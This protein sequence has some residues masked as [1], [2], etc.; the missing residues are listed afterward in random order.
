MKQLQSLVWKEWH[1]VRWFLG[2]ALGLFVGMPILGALEGLLISEYRQRHFYFDA[3]PW[4]V[5]FGLGGVLAVMVAVGLV[6]LDLGG[7]REDFLRSRPLHLARWVLVKYLVGLIVVV[8]TCTLPLV[9]E[10]SINLFAFNH[11]EVA[12][13]WYPWLWIALYSLSFLCACLVRR[14]AHATMLAMAAMLLLYFLPVVLPFLKYISINWV[15]DRSLRL[16]THYPA[17]HT[18]LP[19]G[20]RV[21]PEQLWFVAGM[22]LI[23]AVALLASVIT[24]ARDWRVESGTKSMYWSAGS[25]LLILFASASFRLASNLP[26]LQQITLPQDQY[27]GQ[28]LFSG[29]RGIVITEEPYFRPEHRRYARTISLGEKGL[30]LG[31]AVELFTWNQ[32]N[33]MP[34]H[35]GMLFH[36]RYHGETRAVGHVDLHILS[37]DGSVPEQSVHLWDVDPKQWSGARACGI[38]DRIYALGSEFVTIDV[39]NPANAKIKLREPAR[40]SKADFKWS[41]GERWVVLSRLSALS[42]RQRLEMQVN[43]YGQHLDGDVLVDAQGDGIRTYVLDRLD[44]NLAHFTLAGSYEPSLLEHVFGSSSYNAEATGGFAYLQSRYLEGYLTSTPRLTAYD[45][46]DPRRPHPV[47]HFAV[48]GQHSLHVAAAADGRLIIAADR[49]YLVGKPPVKE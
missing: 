3:S 17:T 19:G 1:E 22:L 27:V 31:P 48:A 40:Y 8:V 5:K 45:I 20:A 24:V 12:V 14:M 34:Q 33:W 47:G 13:I 29:T 6:C 41:G 16:A 49:I 46:H 15:M 2:I 44:D 30:E 18:R 35:P 32:M 7:R 36:I 4:I 28:L 23:S 38:G 39:S 9:I 11:T 21:Q 43:E 10:L 25:V 37:I 42:P 26:I